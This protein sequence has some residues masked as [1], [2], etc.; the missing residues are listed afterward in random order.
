MRSHRGKLH[1]DGGKMGDDV[2]SRLVGIS[3]D[4]AEV[5]DSI[6]DLRRELRDYMNALPLEIITTIER[7]IYELR[8]ARWE[9]EQAGLPSQPP[10]TPA[11][12]ENTHRVQSNL[13][14]CENENERLRLELGILHSQLAE[15]DRLIAK[16]KI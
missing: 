1:C 6:G 4:I 15:K 8:R 9:S 10:P 14:L 12:T 5:T 13:A 11:P 7:K 2:R 16:S 3:D